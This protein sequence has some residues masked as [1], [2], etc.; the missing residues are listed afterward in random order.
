MNISKKNLK[1]ARNENRY[2]I[3]IYKDKVTGDIVYRN[4][5]GVIIKIADAVGIAGTEADILAL[6]TAVADLTDGT[7]STTSISLSD[8]LVSNLAIKIGADANNGI[9]GVSDTQLGIAVEGTLVG[10][11]NTTGLFTD[12]ISEQTSTAG[13]TIDGVLLKDNTVTNNNGLIK[14][15]KSYVARLVQPGDTSAPTVTV[16]ENNLSAAIVWTRN[17][18]G[19]YYGTL[20]GTFTAA[21]FWKQASFDIQ[22]QG[23][24]VAGDLVR[25]NDDFVAINIYDITYGLQ[26][27]GFQAD[28]EIRV[29]N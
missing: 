5:L 17:A 19:Q 7:V 22:Q 12:V 18:T 11:F 20:V 23:T 21:K 2:T 29:Y 14:P 24:E 26:V 4:P 28:I 3:E 9:Y 1:D 13:V 15:Y 8:G 27:D 16:F 25:Q 6:Q 10:G